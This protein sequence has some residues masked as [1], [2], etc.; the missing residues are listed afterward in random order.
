MTFVIIQN[1]V[2]NFFVE[3]KAS[4]TSQATSRQLHTRKLSVNNTHF[5]SHESFML[6]RTLRYRSM[7]SFSEFRRFCFLFVCGSVSVGS[8]EQNSDDGDDVKSSSGT[9]EGST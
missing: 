3:I 5:K 9:E 2:D 4:H 7:I 1:L 6:F 8:E